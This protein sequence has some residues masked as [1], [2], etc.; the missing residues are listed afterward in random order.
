MRHVE[1]LE[2]TQKWKKSVSK[3]RLKLANTIL[4]FFSYIRLNNNRIP[5]SIRIILKPRS[6][7]KE[8]EIKCNYQIN[9]S[10]KQLYL[11]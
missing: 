1:T 8:F 9:I 5:F 11:L 4:D 6:T 2:L 7:G 10:S 3:R